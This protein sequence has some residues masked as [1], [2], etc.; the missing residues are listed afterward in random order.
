MLVLSY[1]VVQNYLFNCEK[2]DLF[3]K[4]VVSLHAKSYI[5]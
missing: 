5:R 2:G 1:K 4:N 3:Q